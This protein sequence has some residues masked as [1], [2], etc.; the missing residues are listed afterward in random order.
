VVLF[1]FCEGFVVSTVSYQLH[2]KLGGF[3]LFI[4]SMLI[5]PDIYKKIRNEIK[6]K[7]RTKQK[8]KKRK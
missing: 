3:S 7:E 2:I 5:C 8:Q 1:S 4:T 6:R